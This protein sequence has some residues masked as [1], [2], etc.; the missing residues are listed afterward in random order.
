MFSMAELK[1]QVRQTVHDTLAVPAVYLDDDLVMPAALTVRWH[2]KIDRFG[3]LDG[4]GYPEFIEG[5]DRVIF[6]IPELVAAGVV[7]QEGGVLT[8]AIQDIGD[9]ELVLKVM[10]PK[11]GPVQEIWQVAKKP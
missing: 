10:E 3:D 8:I 4:G 5:I 6:N 7:L 9:V 1:A 11:T 2:T